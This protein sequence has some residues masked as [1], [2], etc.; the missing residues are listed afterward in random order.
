M[1]KDENDKTLTYRHGNGAKD[2]LRYMKAIAL[3]VG[4]FLLCLFCI[5]SFAGF[6][7]IIV[8]PLTGVMWGFGVLCAILLP[9][10]RNTILNETCVTIGCYVAALVV[11]EQ[12]ISLISG[13]S[14]ETLMA[15]FNQVVSVTGG[16]TF[17]GY[18]NT[19]MWITTIM[20]PIGFVGLQVKRLFTFKRKA[21]KAKALEQARGIRE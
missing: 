16:S 21:N 6:G 20:T 14:A 9:S 1:R 7:T 10:H 11:I 12:L 4:I 13:V 5:S 15:A 18:L 19:F 8:A 3:P 2:I 17:A